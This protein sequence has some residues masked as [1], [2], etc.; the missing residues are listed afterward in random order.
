VSAI[1]RPLAERSTDYETTRW[2]EIDG[3]PY[4]PKLGAKADG[5]PLL[6]E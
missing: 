2:V 4:G 1:G 5:T 6:E 3:G